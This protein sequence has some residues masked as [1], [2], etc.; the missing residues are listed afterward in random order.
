LRVVTEARVP[1]CQVSID[2]VFD[3]TRWIFDQYSTWGEGPRVTE[4]TPSDPL[5]LKLARTF[6][7][8]VNVEI[9]RAVLVTWTQLMQLATPAQ[10]ERMGPTVIPRARK[11]SCPEAVALMSRMSA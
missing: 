8:R 11:V 6:L 10:V 7:P 9:Q 1:R 3:A 2:T 5:R 4:F